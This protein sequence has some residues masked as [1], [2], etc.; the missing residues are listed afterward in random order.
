MGGVKVWKERTQQRDDA[1][2]TGQGQVGFGMHDDVDEDGLSEEQKEWMEEYKE[3]MK[4]EQE[5]YGGGEE[6]DQEEQNMKGSEKEEKDDEVSPFSAICRPPAPSPI[7]GRWR[8]PNLPSVVHDGYDAEA[9]Q[10]RARNH[11]LQ[12]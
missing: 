12:C 10:C 2:G 8:G 11:R 9:A 4:R 3:E 5:R 1:W 7:C 6:G